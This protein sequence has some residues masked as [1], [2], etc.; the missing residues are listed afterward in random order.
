MADTAMRRALL[1][2]CLA[3][4][5]ACGDDS[6]P[7]RGGTVVIGAGS[8]LDHAN[9]LVSA[10]AWTNEILRFLLFAP[11]VRY[12]PDLDF[13]PW[14]AERWETEGDTVFVFH[15]R[16]DVTW[17]DGNPTTARDVLFTFQRA[18]NPE[19]GFPNRGH[20]DHWLEGEVVDSFTI[21]FRVEPH[22][23]PL[24]AW[25][26]TPIVPS[27][28]LDTI[29]PGEMRNAP[30]N[31]NPVGNGP[32]RFVSQRANDRWIFE[33]N[34]DFPEGMGGPP[35]LDRL[36][37]RVIPDN[38]GQMTEL[39][40]GSVDLVLQP[41]PDQ[42]EELGQRDGLQVVGK[43]SR[44]FYFIA[45]NGSRPPLDDP[46]VRRAMALAIDRDRI[47]YGLRKG[48]GAP[49]TSP[50]Q[51]SHWAYDD[52]LRPVPHDR[53]AA[54]N[55]LAEAGYATPRGRAGG[56]GP[57]SVELKFPAGSELHRDLAEAIRSDLA[58]V[59]LEVTTRAT[60]MGTLI[61]DVTSPDRRFDAALL[62]WTADFRLNLR[63]LFHSDAVRGP[64]QFASYAN[65]ELDRLI[66]S[67][68]LEPSRDVAMPMWRRVQELLRDDQPW[69]VLFYNQDAYL[70]RDRLR[71]TD[72][73]IRGA[74]VNVQRWWV[75]SEEPATP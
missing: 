66:D 11:L 27:H 51:P 46:R 36:V 23:E 57:L 15:L 39:R 72:M 5:G 75:D 33:R 14:L 49:A 74:L 2:L 19:T 53:D 7:R 26:T 45:W 1:V 4:L 16:R 34:P 24:A 61:G 10:E 35:L 8:D 6:A 20:F 42:V 47:L 25:P 67:A 52:S 32:F 54:R 73:D 17:H 70:A 30:F 65:P 71:G 9:T 29:P 62:G 60:E 44:Q 13:Q 68:S 12:G 55:L 38:T 48:M 18:R 58:A 59:G 40:V 3:F 43:P 56:A 63:D 28:L 69:T 21:R 64:Y 31:R 50:V 41:R 37:W 22:A